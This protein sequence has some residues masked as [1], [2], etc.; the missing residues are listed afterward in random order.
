MVD[1]SELVI[2]EEDAFRSRRVACV[3]GTGQL[4]SLIAATPNKNVLW[5]LYHEKT[6]LREDM[7]S[8]RQLLGKDNC[9]ITDDP[10]MFQLLKADGFALGERNVKNFLI[11]IPGT[12][13]DVG[14]FCNNRIYEY[15]LSLFY[16]VDKPWIG[17]M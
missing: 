10:N 1:T 8:E 13:V 14:L 15:A 3:L 9:W 16:T 17:R 5:R 7:E 6:R 11:S 2:D 4:A 12:F